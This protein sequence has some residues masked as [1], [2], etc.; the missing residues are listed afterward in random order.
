VKTIAQ[1][2]IANAKYHRMEGITIFSFF[3]LSIFFIHMG[4]CL[5]GSLVP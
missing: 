4:V 1:G 3:V 5:G 2:C